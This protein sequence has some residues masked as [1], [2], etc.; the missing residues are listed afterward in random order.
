MIFCVLWFVS[1]Q[2]HLYQSWLLHRHRG[3]LTIAPVPIL[4]RHRGN[5]MIAPVPLKYTWLIWVNVSH[6]S[7]RN[8]IRNIIWQQ[9]T[10]RNGKQR[11]L[12]CLLYKTCQISHFAHRQKVTINKGFK[13][14]HVKSYLNGNMQITGNILTWPPYEGI[15]VEEITPIHANAILKERIWDMIAG[16]YDFEMKCWGY[17]NVC[18][19]C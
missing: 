12:Y 19:T 2:F 3:N 6:E 10:Q 17:K 8:S 11:I 18:Q 5:L 9:Q 1:V 15:T 16:L 4:H 13:A 14:I 7:I